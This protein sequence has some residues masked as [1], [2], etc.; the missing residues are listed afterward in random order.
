MDLSFE[1]DYHWRIRV[2]IRDVGARGNLLKIN[3]E[4]APLTLCHDITAN[5]I[6]QFL[7]GYLLRFSRCWETNDNSIPNLVINGPIGLSVMV[8]WA[9]A[10]PVFPPHFFFNTFQFKKVLWN[11]KVDEKKEHMTSKVHPLR[12]DALK[13]KGQTRFSRTASSK[14][15]S[16]VVRMSRILPCIGLLV[17]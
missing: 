14:V 17:L 16:I 9:S 1:S 12:C 8:G 6:C 11:R 7:Y 13:R 15:R 2:S 10:L 4:D 5:S 3:Q